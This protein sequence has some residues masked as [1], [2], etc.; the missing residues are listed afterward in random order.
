MR[1]SVA[2]FVLPG[3]AEQQAPPAPPASPVPVTR[4]QTR[5]ATRPAPD[6]VLPE[7]PRPQLARKNWTNLNG[8]WSYAITAAD[9]PRPAAFD[10]KI[11]VPF[12][13]ESQLS[14]AGA[15]DVGIAD[16]IESSRAK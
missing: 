13:I 11:L 5:W 4:L 2:A 1:L 3:V 16:V 15:F 8:T 10:G 9:A 7:Y 6:K 14:G 12:P